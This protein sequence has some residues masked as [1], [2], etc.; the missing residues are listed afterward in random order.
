MSLI[1][2][3]DEAISINTVNTVIEA[4]TVK[5]N[6]NKNDIA[7]LT[8]GSSV[9]KIKETTGNFIAP[10]NDGKVEIT[11]WSMPVNNTVIAVLFKVNPAI[12]GL[13]KA[14]VYSG[15]SLSDSDH[16]MTSPTHLNEMKQGRSAILFT[17]RNPRHNKMFANTR[18]NAVGTVIERTVDVKFVCIDHTNEQNNNTIA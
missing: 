13:V 16:L 1:Y 2:G 9:I 10:T 11:A 6:K 5:I 15:V 7:K 8:Q 4:N 17:G 18:G 3:Y 12:T 14:S